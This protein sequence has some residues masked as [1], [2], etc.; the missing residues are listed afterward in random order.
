[1]RM[2]QFHDIGAAGDEQTF[3]SR[4]IDLANQMDFGIVS[5][6]LV[7]TRPGSQNPALQ[8][9]GNTPKAFMQTHN[10]RK[11]V[12]RDPVMNRA[13]ETSIP[14]IYDEQT[15]VDGDATDLYDIQKQYGYSTGI[16]VPLQLRCNRLFVLGVDRSKQLPK[17]EG[18]R[19]QMMGQVQMLAVYAAE[20]AVSLYGTKAPEVECP[21]TN[22]ELEALK[23]TLAGKTAWEAGA[24][25]KIATGTVNCHLTAA[26]DK[27]DAANKIGAA[28]KALRLGWISV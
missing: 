20:A 14:F 5:G 16:V 11:L 17:D 27:L 28:L 10:D 8:G 15:Y 6:S 21:L 22:R 19:I 2:Q 3:A 9:F 25:M 1:M 7:T 12:S 24:I 4:V 23:W 13:K 18:R 26:K